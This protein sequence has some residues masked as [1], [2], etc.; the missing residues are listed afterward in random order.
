M[1]KAARVRV[2]IAVDGAISIQSG[3]WERREKAIGIGAVVP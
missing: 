1:A 2:F 3:P